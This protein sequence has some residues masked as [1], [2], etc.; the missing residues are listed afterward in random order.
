MKTILVVRDGKVVEINPDELQ[1]SKSN[2]LLKEG[3][4][5]KWG[6]K[7]YQEVR[8]STNEKGQRRIFKETKKSKYYI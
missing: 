8:I 2:I 3:S 5:L 1:E 7:A 4:K 6:D